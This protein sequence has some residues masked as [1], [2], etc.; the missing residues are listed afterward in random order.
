MEQPKN[1]R[2]ESSPDEKIVP[3]KGGFV[4][5]CGS[6]FKKVKNIWR[7]NITAECRRRSKA[8]KDKKKKEVEETL[9]PVINIF[10]GQEH[11][12]L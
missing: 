4:F 1:C 3:I 9:C 7:W 8:I 6:S 10:T 12:L 5:D 2:C 11:E